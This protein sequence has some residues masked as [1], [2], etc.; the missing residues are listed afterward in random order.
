MRILVGFLRGFLSGGISL[1][2]GER[3]EGCWNFGFEKL[4]FYAVWIDDGWSHKWSSIDAT[5]II[6]VFVLYCIVLSSNQNS[7]NNNVF[8]LVFLIA[9]CV[10]F[11]FFFW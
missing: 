3:R 10:F 6:F 8:F 2:G 9:C 4:G 11:V 7:S 5:I 1:G